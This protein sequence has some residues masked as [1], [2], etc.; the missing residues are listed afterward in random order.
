MMV[1]NPDS[2]TSVTEISG[3]QRSSPA[4][5]NTTTGS[6][7][8]NDHLNLTSTQ[9]QELWQSLSKQAAKESF[10]SIRR[11]CTDHLIVLNAEHL[12][13]N[14]CEIQRLL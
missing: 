12:T 13:A 1:I 6:T 9:R 7:T 4:R 10:G 2:V 3:G 8:A 11:E 5:D 14:S